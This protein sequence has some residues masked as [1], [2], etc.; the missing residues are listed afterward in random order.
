MDESLPVFASGPFSFHTKWMAS[1]TSWNSAQ[2]RTD[3][4]GQMAVGLQCHCPFPACIPTPSQSIHEPN[5]ALVLLHQ[6]ILVLVTSASPVKGASATVRQD[7]GSEP[8]AQTS[9]CFLWPVPTW[10]QKYHFPLMGDCCWTHLKLWG[11]CLEKLSSQ[12]SMLVTWMLT[13]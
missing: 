2:G 13:V 8:R 4:H 9:S 7:A 5:W 12:R 1:C 11:T 10:S 3:T 6:L